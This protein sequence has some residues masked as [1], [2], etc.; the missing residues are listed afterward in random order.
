[1]DQPLGLPH[2][3]VEVQKKYLC[4]PVSV[5]FSSTHVIVEDFPFL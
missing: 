4:R 1:M 5:V 3:G 2:G